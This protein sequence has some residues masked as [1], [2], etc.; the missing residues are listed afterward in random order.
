MIWT[1]VTHFLTWEYTQHLKLS[2]DIVAD[3]NNYEDR[4]KQYTEFYTIPFQT[5]SLFLKHLFLTETQH[6]VQL[7]EIDIYTF[8]TLIGFNLKSKLIPIM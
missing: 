6:S 1:S 8:K 2:E 7:G 4:I 3:K 5:V